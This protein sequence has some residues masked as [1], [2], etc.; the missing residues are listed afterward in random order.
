MQTVNRISRISRIA[1]KTVMGKGNYIADDVRICENVKIGN[2]NRIYTGTILYPNTSIGD[3]NII[4]EDCRIGE[5]PVNMDYIYDLKY[6]GVKIGNNNAIH[7]R[8]VIFGGNKEQTQIGDNNR[9]SYS[10]HVSHDSVITSNVQLF[11]NTFVGGYSIL[12]PYSGIGIGGGIHQQRV[13]GAYAFIG[14]LSA[15]T[16]NKFPFFIYVGNNATRLNYKRVPK[17]WWPYEDDLMSLQSLCSREIP[18]GIET[19]IDNVGNEELRE[20]LYDF[21]RLST[22]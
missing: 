14:M 18:D 16:R 4:L 12:Q 11:P 5:H 15:A 9:I 1:P 17:S 6:N 8:A 20:Y 13:L 22:I 21:I 2:G 3:G 10:S 19:I 7:S